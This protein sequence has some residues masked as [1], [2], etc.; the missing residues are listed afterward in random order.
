MPTI[1]E[2]VEKQSDPPSQEKGVWSQVRGEPFTNPVDKGSTKEEMNDLYDSNDINSLTKASIISQ[3]SGVAVE[4]ASV[5]AG[6]IESIPNSTVWSK[7]KR[8]DKIQEA[9]S[10]MQIP[11]N[12]VITNTD[13][14][15]A[16]KEKKDKA[17]KK[18]GGWYELV[19]PEWDDQKTMQ[20]ILGYGAPPKIYELDPVNV[21][22]E[23]PKGIARFLEQGLAGTVGGTI[24]EWIGDLIAY[25]GQS[26]DQFAKLGSKNKDQIY[27]PVAESIIALGNRIS[28]RGR[29]ARQWWSYHAQTG[30]EAMDP[31]LKETDPIAY[32]AGRISEGVSSGALAILAAYLSGGATIAPEL[33]NAGIHV[34]RGLLALSTLSAAGG[35]QHAKELGENFLWSTLHGLTDGMI[36][37][38]METSFLDNVSDGRALVAG[39]KEG[40]EE[41]ATGMMQ[42]TRA[43][44]L[45]NT[46]KGL[47]SFDAAKKAI[48]DAL[49]QSPWEV[50][51]NLGH[52]DKARRL[53]HLS[54]LV[55]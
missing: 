30:W 6:T 1:W 51:T 39:L 3:E 45:E 23:V 53:L 33:I 12:S 41:F 7:L 10:Q 42:N 4:D 34:N 54:E 50:T 46:N 14:V 28:E 16:E 40:A 5:M 49:I 2:R 17:E 22:K 20:E 11:L 55:L 52:I 43:G 25:G 48:K 36:E 9:S 47:G 15:L 13:T 27:N 44:I 24:P 8:T 31:H 18:L 37:Y 38:A 35:Y 21:L 19:G 32:G 29:L 26:L